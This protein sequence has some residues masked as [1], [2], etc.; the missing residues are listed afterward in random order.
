MIS[1]VLSGSDLHQFSKM[2]LGLQVTWIFR[3]L[4][5][6][7]TIA[8]FC[9]CFSPPCFI[10]WELALFSDHGS[11]TIEKLATLR[12]TYWILSVTT[13]SFPGIFPKMHFSHTQRLMLPSPENLL[14]SFVF[15]LSWPAFKKNMH[16]WHIV[17]IG[18]D[19]SDVLRWCL[20]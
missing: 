11:L 9:F 8:C 6:N 5:G 18:R 14:E 17:K 13:L 1:E 2:H 16:V 10:A 15:C 7:F 3:T 19:R 20:C 12:P 4:D